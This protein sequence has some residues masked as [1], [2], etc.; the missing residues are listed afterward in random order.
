[1]SYWMV[2]YY[3]PLSTVW[4]MEFLIRSGTGRKAI[5]RGREYGKTL[6]GVQKARGMGQGTGAWSARKDGGLCKKH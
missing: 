3:S 5:E 4:R 2:T 1:M 6:P